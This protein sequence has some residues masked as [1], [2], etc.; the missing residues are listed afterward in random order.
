MC[1]LYVSNECQNIC[2][3]CGFSL[4]NKIKRKTLMDFEIKLEVCTKEAS[5]DHVLLVAGEANY[6]VN[7]NFFETIDV[8][9]DQFSIISIEVQPLSQE[10]YER[11][12]E[13]GVYSV[14]VYQETYHQDVYK[15][16]ILRAIQFDFRLDTQTAL[17]SRIHKI[18]LVFYGSGGLAHR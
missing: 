2:T 4:D 5:F 10:E 13:A 7:I 11:L 15:S 14:L 8:I 3:Y 6:T 12:H 16:I 1:A 18:G 9:K 17:V